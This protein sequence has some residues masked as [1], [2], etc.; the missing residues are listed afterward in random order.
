MLSLSTPRLPP[1]PSRPQ[2]PLRVQ[3]PP[4][5][6]GR[7]GGAGG[8]IEG[9]CR[10]ERNTYL[11]GE[12]RQLKQ[13]DTLLPR[14]LNGR[15]YHWNSTRLFADPYCLIRF[16]SCPRKA[17]KERQPCGRRSSCYAKI[18]F[19]CRKVVVNFSKIRVK[20]L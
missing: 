2:R 12:A 1:P 10:L 6:G 17:K 13:R 7:R 18:L 3:I 20:I 15:K 8:G 11:N 16:K 14:T 19:I 4:R 5:P 9:I